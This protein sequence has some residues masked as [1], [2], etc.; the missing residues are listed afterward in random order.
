MYPQDL[1]SSCLALLRWTVCVGHA[2][3]YVIKRWEK[4]WNHRRVTERCTTKRG[5]Q[6]SLVPFP[7][8]N[9]SSAGRIQLVTC[10]VLGM[11]SPLIS[12]SKKGALSILQRDMMRPRGQRDDDC[13]VF[14]LTGKRQA[15]T[16]RL[17]GSCTNN[18]Y[19][20]PQIPG[21][22]H[23]C[24]PSTAVFSRRAVLYRCCARFP[25]L[26]TDGQLRGQKVYYIERW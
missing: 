1:N 16:H 9:Q 25:R 23:F 21:D 26:A 15:A 24:F 11:F 6:V 10:G 14:L 7:S 12:I 5:G 20:V 22:N 18:P 8:N 19:F 3:K 17:Q 2:Q 13:S 4:H